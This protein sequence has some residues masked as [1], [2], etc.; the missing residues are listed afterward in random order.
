MQIIGEFDSPE[1]VIDDYGHTASSG[2][3]YMLGNFLEQVHDQITRTKYKLMHKKKTI[4]YR[5]SIVYPFVNMS[6]INGHYIISS[7]D[8]VDIINY[9]EHY[10]LATL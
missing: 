5:E 8:F 6:E 9:V 7:R 1:N 3:K 10:A 4:F 2:Q